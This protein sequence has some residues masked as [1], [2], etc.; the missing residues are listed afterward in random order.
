MRPVTAMSTPASPRLSFDVQYHQYRH[1]PKP[2][3]RPRGRW[4]WAISGLVV[5]ALMFASISEALSQPDAV[6]ALPSGVK[7]RTIALN[8][9]ITQLSVQSYGGNVQ[10][11]GG[12]RRTWVTEQVS[13]DP[14]VESAPAVV[15]SVSDGRLTLAVPA[16]ATQ[17]CMDQ[18]TVTVPSTASVTIVTDGGDVSV[19]GVAGATLDSGGGRVRAASISGPLTVASE[20]GAQ[21]LL[22]IAGSLQDESGGGEVHAV[23]VTGSSAVIVTDGG[24]LVAERLS[25]R[26]AIL[27]S[28]GDNA[29]VEF[30]TPPASVDIATDGGDATV[31][32][33]GGPYALTADSDGASQAVEIPTSA[34]ATSTLTVTTGGNALLI[35]PPPG[36]PAAGTPAAVRTGAS[37]TGTDQH[38]APVPP[39]APSAPALPG[40]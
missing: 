17:G 15:N 28:G 21:E 32:I 11:I 2:P 27:S 9:S 14:Q 4:I 38:A 18:F 35:E 40:P 8:Q 16:C 22:G 12:G 6:H 36:T 31:L 19:S 39:P 29:R 33:P 23:G 25:V 5:I 10:V 37:A 1:G 26:A 30:A 13:Y 7:T 20:G 34:A 3:K 24:Q